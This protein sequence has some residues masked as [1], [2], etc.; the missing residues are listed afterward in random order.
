M[1]EMIEEEEEEEETSSS[2]EEEGRVG[3]H[4]LVNQAKELP[5][6]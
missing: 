4:G 5:V 2:E 6:T 1:E 3:N